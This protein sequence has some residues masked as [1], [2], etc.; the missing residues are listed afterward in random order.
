MLPAGIQNGT[1]SENVLSEKNIREEEIIY[2]EKQIFKEQN[3]NSIILTI[4]DDRMEPYY[5]L[6]DNIGGI[7][8][9]NNEMHRYIGNLC[10]IELENSLIIPSLLQKGTKT[11]TYNV[12]CT[13]PKTTASSLNH[14]NVYVI[15]VAPILWHRRK[16]STVICRTIGSSHINKDAVVT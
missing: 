3:H 4:V 15:K 16:I 2:R 14:Y 10:I 5:S 8:V 9:P 6:G 7:Q 13:N 12:C 1:G 11:S